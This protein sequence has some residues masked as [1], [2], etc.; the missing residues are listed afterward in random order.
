MKVVL[1]MAMT[2]NGIIARKN[3]EED[4]LS[5]KNWHVFRNL[6]QKAGCLVVGRKTY[7]I[8]KKKYKKYSFEDI[9]AKKMVVS[10][11]PKFR[12]QGYIVSRSPKDAINKAKKQGVKTLILTGGGNL[13]AS[14][15]KSNLVDEIILNIEPA[16]LGKGIP[17]FA[18]DNFEARLNL[19]STKKLKSGIVQLHYN[20]RKK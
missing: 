4:F 19:I 8:V 12:P 18:E 7:D 17:V 3:Y 9:K 2:A 1:Y 15:M 14:F 13:N 20:V 10:R 5:D 16:V 6:A 11:N